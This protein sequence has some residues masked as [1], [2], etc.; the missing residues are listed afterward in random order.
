MSAGSPEPVEPPAEIDVE[1]SSDS[2]LI[3]LISRGSVPAFVALFDRTS[4]AARAELAAGL[5]DDRRVSEVLA[6][7]YVEVW[8]LAG[9]ERAPEVDGMSWIVSILRRRISDA[10]RLVGR[11]AALTVSRLSYAELELAALLQRPVDRLTRVAPG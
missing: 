10:A 8:W 6:A 2:T 9:C 3:E 11:P 7:T 5:P 1:G 4:E